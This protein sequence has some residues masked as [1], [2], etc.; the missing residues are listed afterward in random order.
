MNWPDVLPPMR[1]NQTFPVVGTVASEILGPNPRRRAVL[2]GAPVPNPSNQ[3]SATVIAQ[4]ADTSATGVVLSYTVP[5]GQSAIVT[6]VS[7]IQSAGSSAVLTMQ[8][9]RGATTIDMGSMGLLAE[10]SLGWAVDAGDTVQ[11]NVTTADAGSTADL[12]IYI[13]VTQAVPRVTLSFVNSPTLDVGVNLYA[14]NRPLFLA[15]WHLGSGI[16]ES[17]QA[18]ASVAGTQISVVEWFDG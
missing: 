2:I 10:L 17:V 13:S 8:L 9:V 16:T 12:G 18:I 1:R 11:A 5:A 15:G 6:G 3:A 7:M 4:A 14:G